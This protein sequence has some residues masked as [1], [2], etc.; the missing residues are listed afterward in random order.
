MTSSI[1]M[2]VR[3]VLAV[4][5]CAAASGCD[6]KLSDLT[7]PTPSLEPTFA[8]VQTLIIS[9][10]D[11]AGR[12]ACV[13][14][15]TNQGRNPAGLLNMAVDPYNALVNASSRLRP[16][17]TFVIPGNPTDSYLIRKLRGGPD[18]SGVRMPF[19]GPPHLTDG[20]IRVIERWIELGARDN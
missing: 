14:C 8:S 4:G 2:F 7:G 19:N 6:E 1:G 9:Q 5:L 16:G 10:P 12:V 15:H 13:S 20:Q 18:I 17:E 11:V 3:G